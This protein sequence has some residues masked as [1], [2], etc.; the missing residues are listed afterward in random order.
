MRSCSWKKCHGNETT[1]MKYVALI[2]KLFLA[3]EKLVKVVCIVKSRIQSSVFKVFRALPL[4][5]D[6]LVVTLSLK[7]RPCSWQ[8]R[9]CHHRHY[10]CLFPEET[11]N[12]ALHCEPHFLF[13]L[14]L[15]PETSQRTE[16]VKNTKN[17]SLFWRPKAAGDQD[18]PGSPCQPQ[19]GH[20]NTATPSCCLSMQWLTGNL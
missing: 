1:E 17:C 5:Q 14:F 3:Y 7:A 19:Q 20:G 9:D 16:M 15:S 10:P 11:T 13:F 2:L 4:P 6:L 8:C 12:L 18:S